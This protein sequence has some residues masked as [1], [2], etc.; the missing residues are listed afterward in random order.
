MAYLHLFLSALA[1]N[2]IGEQ[3]AHCCCCCH[4]FHS[5]LLAV[6]LGLVRLPLFATSWN[7]VAGVKSF[8]KIKNDGK[9]KWMQG[10]KL[11]A[12]STVS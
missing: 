3:A 10:W 1:I 5:S 6:A 12:N 7:S 8:E 11:V 4:L 9:K 2:C